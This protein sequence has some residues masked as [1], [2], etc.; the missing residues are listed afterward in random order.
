LVQHIDQLEQGAL[1]KVGIHHLLA[2]HFAKVYK[3]NMPR[4]AA[5]QP[6]GRL[7]RCA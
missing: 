5:A 2:E 1:D 6:Q 4:G 3:V 7:P